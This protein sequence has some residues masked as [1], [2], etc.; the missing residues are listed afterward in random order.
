MW[1]WNIISDMTKY[2]VLVSYLPNYLRQPWIKGK[3]PLSQQQT[4]R[5]N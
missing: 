2:W 4:L 5:T 3:P 1:N